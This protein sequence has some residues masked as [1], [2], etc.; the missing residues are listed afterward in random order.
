MLNKLVS[1]IIPVH[2]E[3]ANLARGLPLLLQEKGRREILV[4]DGGSNDGGPELAASLPGVTVLHAPA[5]CRAVQ[6]NCGARAAQGSVLAFLHADTLLPPGAISSLTG[7]LDARGADFGAFP[8]RFD[9][10][11]F[12]ID[13]LARLTRIERPWTCFGDQAIFAR[14]EFFERTGGFP[15]QGILEDVHW[16][17]RAA[18]L[19][20]MVRPRESAVTSARRFQRN[21]ELEQLF[22][23]GWILALDA[24]GVAPARLAELYT[25]PGR[26]AATATPATRLAERATL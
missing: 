17:R 22:M 4:C 5:R 12:W 3:L 21:G 10:P 25:R 26:P 13:L 2:N 8:V 1:V 23:N 11:L 16:I 7:L 18:R 6:M 15:A 9:P 24:A 19:G 20:R 14:R